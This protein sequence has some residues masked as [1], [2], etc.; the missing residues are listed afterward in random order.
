MYDGGVDKG[1]I[2]HNRSLELTSTSA[3]KTSGPFPKKGTV[4]V[5]SDADLVLFD[6]SWERTVSPEVLCSAQDFT[7]FAG[8]RVRG[9]P[10]RTLLRG[11]TAFHDGT[12]QGR[13]QGQYVKR[14]VGRHSAAV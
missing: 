3:A 13:P 10:R 14:P 1:R 5:G 7:P 11:R 2:S 12:V 9:W 8:M 6:P 4:A